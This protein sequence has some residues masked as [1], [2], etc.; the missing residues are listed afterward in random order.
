[1]TLGGISASF[2]ATAEVVSG[3]STGIILHEFSISSTKLDWAAFQ[4]A[5]AA[6]QNRWKNWVAT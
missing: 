3:M 4:A 5:F 6:T 2:T 1:V